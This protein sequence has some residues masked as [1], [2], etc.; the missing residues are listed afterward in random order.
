MKKI[1]VIITF[2][3]RKDKTLACLKQLFNSFHEYNHQSELAVFLTDDGSSDG[4]SD[5]ITA[6]FPTYN[7]KILQGTGSLYWAGGMRKAWSE[8]IK[9]EFDGYLLLNDDTLVSDNLFNEIINTHK[10]CTQ[11]Y[12]TGGIYIGTTHSSK[13]TNL[14]TYGGTKILN[15]WRQSSKRVVPNGI[16][17]QLCDLGNANIMFATNDVVQKIGILCKSYTHALADYDY[18]LSAKKKNIPVL[19]MANL[20]GMCDIDHINNYKLFEHIKLKDRV[21]FAYS[22]LGFEFN[23][24]LIYN[25]RHFWYRL[26]FVFMIGWLRILLPT[27]FRNTSH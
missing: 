24:Y 16:S 11:K 14:I 15:Y 22:P 7:I 1:A 17:P 25:M 12:K 18:T 21:V 26:P 13:N 4:T 6:N 2:H 27:L 8:A 5:A 19:I 9:D 20:C 3:N 23:N 10:F